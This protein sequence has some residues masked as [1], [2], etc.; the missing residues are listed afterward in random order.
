M[1]IISAHNK[2]WLIFSVIFFVILALVLMVIEYRHERAIRTEALEK[3][4]D[5]YSLMVNNYI[6]AGNIAEDSSFSRIDSLGY[7]FTDNLRVTVI[8]DRGNVMYDSRAEESMMENH[9][10]RPEIQKALA[11]GAGSAVRVS[12]TTGIK[13][14]YHARYFDGYFVRTS[15]VY[16]INARQ[17]LKPD[18]LFL[19]LVVFILFITVFTIM[20]ISDKFGES[21]ETLRRFT[22]NVL[23]NKPIDSDTAF[24]GNE[25]G[26]IGSKI[27]EI[28]RNL[29]NTKE[30]LIRERSKL[31]RH[32]NLLEDGIGLFS[33]DKKVITKNN[34]FIILINQI[35]NERI[36]TAEDVF[37]IPDFRPL[38][39]FID[40]NI[41]GSAKEIPADLRS[42]EITINKGVR[43][44]I[45][46]AA[47]FEDNSFEISIQDDTKLAKRKILK[48]ELTENIAHELRTPVS[49]IRGL[50]ETVLESSPDPEKTRDFLRRAWAQSCRLTELI[51]DIAMLTKIE[52]AGKLYKIE[53][54]RL[55][56]II[57][58]V[59]QELHSGLAENDIK[60]NVNID[61]NLTIRGNAALVYSIFRNLTDN[62]INHSG[63]GVTVNIEK[64]MEDDDN[65]YILFE[66][67]GAG[68][69]EHD[70]P[71]LF[72]R[73]YRVDKGRDRKKGGTGL[74][75]SIVN[76][77]V[78]FHKGSISARNIP[79]GG[80]QFIFTISRLL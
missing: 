39:D 75:L 46:R 78:K 20:V 36:Y 43:H 58:E 65:Y 59:T 45:S 48:Q 10:M 24:P 53:E 32:L 49:S 12:A 19:L 52:E 13:Y 40:R 70:I 34:H 30:E 61:E 56:D 11:E 50:L 80:L 5:D 68:V 44:F 73:F 76:N 14:Y 55:Y 64:F 35:S 16:D 28:Y 3:R 79:G 9:L 26:D 42:Y 25:L 77:A 29:I 33:P 17:M 27:V 57:A 37:Q 62:V 41:K 1:K 54:V 6:S 22:V 63:R 31:I 23:D 74:G 2:K 66:D 60:I 38:A 51:D 67:N 71:R 69:P 47:I 72:E 18:L 21:V 7:L 15:L 4:L 8:D